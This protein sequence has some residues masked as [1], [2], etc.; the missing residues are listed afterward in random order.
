[1][2]PK[3]ITIMALTTE[4]NAGRGLTLLGQPH[5][6]HDRA[7]TLTAAPQSGQAARAGRRA[8]PVDKVERNDFFFETASFR[9]ASQNGQ[10]ESSASKSARHCG[11]FLRSF[12]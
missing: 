12:M 2:T 5:W 6:G 11:H 10:A 3:N 4:R 1:M 7:R 9:T 8:L